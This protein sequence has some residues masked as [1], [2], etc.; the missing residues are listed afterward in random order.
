M[1]EKGIIIKNTLGKYFHIIGFFLAFLYV[2]GY[3]GAYFLY[4]TKDAEN[5][6]FD[7]E[8]K[9]EVSDVVTNRRVTY[10]LTSGADKFRIVIKDNRDYS[11]WS[12]SDF[13]EKKDKVFKIKNSDT[14]FVVR[15]LKR[16]YFLLDDH[17]TSDCD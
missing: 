13:L 16:Y 12:F 17:I 8:F 10:I 11:I 4:R 7:S 3:R 14:V 9:A 1:F 5:I 2:F 15:D 6:C